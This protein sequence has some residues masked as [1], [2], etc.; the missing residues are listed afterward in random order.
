MFCLLFWIGWRRFNSQWIVKLKQS[1]RL[2]ANAWS[3]EATWQQCAT[4]VWKGLGD[5]HVKDCYWCKLFFV[6]FKFKWHSQLI[7]YLYIHMR[8]IHK[9]LVL[10]WVT[11]MLIS[12][13][14]SI[15]FITCIA[16]IN[17]INLNYALNRAKELKKSENLLLQFLCY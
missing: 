14:Y 11:V 8:E 4:K 5:P 16:T 7:V 3:S 10:R 6:W 13:F 1:K 17:I 15:H 9:I 12:Y 2:E